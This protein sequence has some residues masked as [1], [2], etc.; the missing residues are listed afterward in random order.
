[1]KPSRTPI[2]RQILHAEGTTQDVLSAMLESIDEVLKTSH[3]DQL[4]HA[5]LILIGAIS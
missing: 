2:T 3:P 5:L 4:R 1:M